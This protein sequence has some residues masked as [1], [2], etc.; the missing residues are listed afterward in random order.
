MR[1][2][3]GVNP[4]WFNFYKL[5]AVVRPG[6]TAKEFFALFTQCRCGMIMT[7]TGLARHY[8]KFTVIDLTKDDEDEDLTVVDLTV[9]Q[10]GL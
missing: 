9:G 3:K 1:E 7:R 6:L 4:G 5:N 10:D 2:E 8:C